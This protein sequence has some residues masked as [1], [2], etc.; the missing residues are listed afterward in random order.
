[1][2]Y[3]HP[4]K[5]IIDSR[6]Q[7]ML[8]FSDWKSGVI[9]KTMKTG[10][11]SLMGFDD[12]LVVERKS[13]TDLV[14]CTGRERERFERCLSRMEL[15]PYRYLLLETSASDIHKGR[16]RSNIHPNQVIGFLNSIQV[17]RK[18]QVL[19]LSNPQVASIFLMNLFDKILKNDLTND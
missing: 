5:I 11:Y 13:L 9:R 7:R 14:M 18:I 15:Y 1:M 2:K 4:N 19:Y 3:N 16:W 12:I 6:E 17:K 8:D 10:D